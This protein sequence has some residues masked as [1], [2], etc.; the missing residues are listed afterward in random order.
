MQF[1]R[2]LDLSSN[3]IGD[4]GAAALIQS[5][6]SL[7]KLELCCADVSDSGLSSVASH[8]S[9]N[10]AK[11]QLRSLNLSRNQFGDKAMDQ[12]CAAISSNTQL[13]AINLSGCG[14]G[15][16]AGRRLLHLIQSLNHSEAVS[17]RHH[18]LQVLVRLELSPPNLQLVPEAFVLL[19]RGLKFLTRCSGVQDVSV[20]H[21]AR[22][23]SV[24]ASSI[25]DSLASRPIQ[26]GAGK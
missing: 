5:C 19:T 9:A 2:H 24:I 20:T 3:D 25:K 21:N 13:Q 12:L 22:M 7:T 1:L 16:A 18:Q 26:P 15:S 14:L 10:S 6:G 4:I 23:D 17:H 11:I 8:L